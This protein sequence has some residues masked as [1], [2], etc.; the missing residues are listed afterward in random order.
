[1]QEYYSIS[2]KIDAEW[3]KRRAKDDG[4]AVFR[5]ALKQK[6]GAFMNSNIKN[7]IIILSA[8][9]VMGGI[10]VAGVK[11]GAYKLGS[12]PKTSDNTS[13][14]G[15]TAQVK[16]GQANT[17]SNVQRGQAGAP[18]GQAMDF[19]RFVESGIVDQETAD[20]MKAYMEEKLQNIEK[21]S[22]GDTIGEKSDIFSGMV[23][24]GIITQEQADKIQ[25]S[26]PQMDGKGMP[27]AGVGN[28]SSI[29]VK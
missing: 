24:A 11:L 16:T 10:L 14:N 23:E 26:T 20:K 13:Q 5:D 4:R 6:E 3:G 29:P 1:M 9:V 27:P 21:D 7:T 18:A 25:A 15:Q 17:G 8:V 19:S 22:Q 2:R 28:N 12:E